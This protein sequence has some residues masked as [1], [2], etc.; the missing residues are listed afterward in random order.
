MNDIVCCTEYANMTMFHLQTASILKNIVNPQVLKCVYSEKQHAMQ[1]WIPTQQ[2]P[3]R[4]L[5]I[6]VNKYSFISLIVVNHSV[7]LMHMITNQHIQL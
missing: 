3:A 1:V 2:C 6:S 4:H 5:S 7:A